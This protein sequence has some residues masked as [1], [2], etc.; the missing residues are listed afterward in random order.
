MLSFKNE[1]KSKGNDSIY[2]HSPYT[3]KGERTLRKGRRKEERK[4][5]DIKKKR[6]EKKI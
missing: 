1:A 3:P 6:K 4:E 2:T 5:E